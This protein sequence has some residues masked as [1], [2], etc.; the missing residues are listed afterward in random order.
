[1]KNGILGLAGFCVLLVG[2]YAG[3]AF[4]ADVDEL[5][6]RIDILSEEMD[7]LM[8][9]A[10][11]ATEHKRFAIHGYGEM[12]YNNNSGSK[13][14]LDNHRFVIGIH[15]ELADWIH[16][17]AEIDYEHAAQELEFEFG[18][19]DFLLNPVA[20]FRAGVMLMPVGALNEFHEPPLFWSAERPFLQQNIIPTTWGAGGVGVFGAV[21][22][23]V[24]YRIYVTNSIQNIRPR[25]FS[26]GEGNG[27][28]G[29]SGQFSTTSGIRG[30]RKQVNNIA[31]EDLAVS[32]RLEFSR[33]APGLQVGFSFFTGDSTQGH[34]SEG[35]RTTII[36]GD[37]KYRRNW[38]DMNASI[39]NIFIDDAK[40]MNAY[41]ATNGCTSQIADN[42]FGYNVQVGVHLLQ[43]MQVSTTHDLVPFVL[44]ERIRP[45]DSMPTG[46]APNRAGNFDVITAG[47][48]YM[49]IPDVA[50]KADYQNL[51]IENGKADQRFNMAVAY[52]Y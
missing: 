5:K 48:S 42:V 21:N 38:F 8:K 46:A 10:G 49:P 31:A 25:G 26:S 14:T 36:E 52:M 9:G 39:V 16:L 24:S 22:E 19:L 13:A 47:V 3:P 37:F 28:G 20:N 51:D 27:N 34:I 1:M 6:R 45:Q 32:G 50:L 30:S 11:G 35:G 15:G 33:L 23:G 17:N 4:A 40:E 44:Y 12:H 18:Y 2:L 29:F 41:C 43:L 7:G